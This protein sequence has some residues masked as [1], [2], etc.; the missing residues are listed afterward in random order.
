MRIV[1]PLIV[2][3]GALAGCTPTQEVARTP[4]GVSYRF[5]GDNI[6]EAN[7]RADRYCQQYGARARLQGVNRAGPADNVAVFACG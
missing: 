3:A 4:P 2:I 1:L 7:A 5:Q 6:G